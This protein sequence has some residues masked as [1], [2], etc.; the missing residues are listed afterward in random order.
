M[1]Y[2]RD[3]S[4]KQAASRRR[5]L[6]AALAEYTCRYSAGTV[7]TAHAWYIITAPR[8]RRI[9]DPFFMLLRSPFPSYPLSSAFDGLQYRLAYIAPQTLRFSRDDKHDVQLL[10]IYCSP[11]LHMRTH[12]AIIWRSLLFGP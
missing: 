11:S 8:C 1:H 6:D 10:Y 3:E 7:K 5:R 12:W 4:G 9:L 2:W